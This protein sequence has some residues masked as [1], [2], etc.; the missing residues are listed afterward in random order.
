MTLELQYKRTLI[1]TLFIILWMNFMG[2]TDVLKNFMLLYFITDFLVFY[3]IIRKDMICHHILSLL[4]IY[5]Y[6]HDDHTTTKKLVMT[7]CS[8]P[9]LMMLNLHI[10]ET[11]NKALFI[12]TFFYFRIFNMWLILVERRYEI[13]NFETW[14]FF[15]LF[16][17][18][19][20]WSEIILRK[21]L[22]PLSVKYIIPHPII[23]KLDKNTSFLWHQS[24][25]LWLY[26]TDMAVLHMLSFYI[27]IKHNSLNNALVSFPLHIVDLLF[28]DT[29]DKIF[30]FSSIGYDVVLVFLYYKQDFLWL[31]GWILAALF[32]SKK[33]FGYETTHPIV[34]FLIGFLIY[35]L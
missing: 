27:S 29:C 6:W 32:N 18:N 11:I 12:S 34:Y 35:N 33:T 15:M 7:E 9:F 20:W 10:F 14:L 25:Q 4:L 3:K 21:H 2:I 26:S 1:S 13:E 19:C 17:L 28:Y 16:L 30:L 24:R 31:L 22:I 5:L 23:R 8:T